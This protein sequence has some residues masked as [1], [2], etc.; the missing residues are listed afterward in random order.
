MLPDIRCPG[1]LYYLLYHV[2]EAAQTRLTRATSHEGLGVRV[3]TG[4]DRRASLSLAR[5]RVSGSWKGLVLSLSCFLRGW[6]SELAARD[7]LRACA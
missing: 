7:L 2:S 5:H 1:Q 4:C 3:A 6:R